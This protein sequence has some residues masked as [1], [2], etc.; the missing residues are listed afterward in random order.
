[1]SEIIKPPALP[2]APA[3]RRND[4]LKR[5]VC[6]VGV[7][8]QTVVLK[9]GNTEIKLDYTSALQV[10]QWMRIRAKEAKRN[11]GDTS[12]HW[13]AIGILSDATRTRG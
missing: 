12:R 10:S 5:E 2:A 8:G 3:V 13:S 7:D 6:S 4:I 9:F 1:M 11:A